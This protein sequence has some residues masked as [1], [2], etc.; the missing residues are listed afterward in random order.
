MKK[1]LFALLVPVVVASVVAGCGGDD[2]T[3]PEP[4]AVESPPNLTGSYTLVSLS[5]PL[6]GGLTVAPPLVAGMFMLTQ[7]SVSGDEARGNLSLSVTYPDG[8]GG[9]TTLTDEGTFVIRTDGSWEQTGAL[10]QAVGTYSLA[11]TVLTVTVSQPPTAAGT[12]VWQRQ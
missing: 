7:T 11:G 5:S 8:M 4:P 6:T 2:T 3:E 9:S 1:R 10:Q 12:T